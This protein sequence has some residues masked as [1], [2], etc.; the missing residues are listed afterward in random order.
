MVSQILEKLF[1]RVIAYFYISLRVICNFEHQL[2]TNQW[3]YELISFHTQI[4]GSKQTSTGK[5]FAQKC[6]DFLYPCMT[7]RLSPRLIIDIRIL[8]LINNIPNLTI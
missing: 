7:F 8:K 2:R 5:H 1:C 6:P 4:T 3:T